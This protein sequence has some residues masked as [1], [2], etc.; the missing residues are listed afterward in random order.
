M[1]VGYH[2]QQ[3]NTVDAT[4]FIISPNLLT[5]F[6]T[7]EKQYSKITAGRIVNPNVGTFYSYPLATIRFTTSV[8][9]NVIEIHYQTIIDR[10]SQWSALASLV[11]M[12]AALC[13][14]G[15]NRNKFNKRNPDWERFDQM[16]K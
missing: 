7:K 14:L 10:V 5:T 15:Y 1:K 9:M 8:V 13:F 4:K 6:T 12:I 2:Q 3:D 11:F 16:L